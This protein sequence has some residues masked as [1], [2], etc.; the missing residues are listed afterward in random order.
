MEGLTEEFTIYKGN[1]LEA[2]RLP[3][4]HLSYKTQY[5][6]YFGEGD[7][8]WNLDSPEERWEYNWHKINQYLAGGIFSS[9]FNF[10]RL[11]NPKETLQLLRTLEKLRKKFSDIE[12]LKEKRNRGEE[13]E[14]NQL[15]K[16]NKEAELKRKLQ[17][18]K[19]DFDDLGVLE[20][21][22]FD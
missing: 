2:N 3:Q 4:K 7:L 16:I 17:K 20:E 21:E 14:E 15:R 8:K 11:E 13:L 19:Q 1:N 6:S 5:L 18:L 9:V 10:P 12:S 22:L